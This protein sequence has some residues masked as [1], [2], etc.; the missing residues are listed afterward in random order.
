MHTIYLDT[1][2][3][4]GTHKT[5]VFKCITFVVVVVVVFVVR[6]ARFVVEKR[7]I[8]FQYVLL[9]TVKVS[10]LSNGSLLLL[11][12]LLVHHVFDINNEV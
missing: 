11:L 8:T 1:N 7:G 9:K 2:N 3:A 12:L 5:V 10:C 4:T 6:V